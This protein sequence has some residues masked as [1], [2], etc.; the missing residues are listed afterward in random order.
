MT[1]VKKIILIVVVAVVFGVVMG[2]RAGLPY[3]WQRAVLAALA[4]GI[5]GWLLVYLSSRRKKD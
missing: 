2:F 3:A 4:F 1:N 5:L